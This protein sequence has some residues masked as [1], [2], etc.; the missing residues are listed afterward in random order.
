MDRTAIRTFRAI[1]ACWVALMLAGCT[2]DASPSPA[3]SEAS[4]PGMIPDGVYRSD[5][6]AEEL[7]DAGVLPGDATNNSGIR[8][9]TLEDGTYRVNLENS[10][11]DCTGTLSVVDGRTRFTED[12]PP[13]CSSPVDPEYFDVSWTIDG[14]QLTLSELTVG[15]PRVE[16][17]EALLAAVFT[18]KPWTI[19]D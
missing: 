2:A 12:Q 16:E 3:S 17:F 15:E 8:T 18:I 6:S 5:L 9:L 14:E 19:I 4:A 11:P 10:S 7:F 13:M 1:A